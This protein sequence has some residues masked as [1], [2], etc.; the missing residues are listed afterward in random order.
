MPEPAEETEAEATIR[1]LVSLQR[2][3]DAASARLDTAKDEVKDAREA[4]L[5]ARDALEAGTRSA[6]DYL[7]LFD[8][9]AAAKAEI[10][11]AFPSAA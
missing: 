7:P 6:G 9:Q 2:A 1:R 5:S 3:V 11:A 8:G 10:D 4:L